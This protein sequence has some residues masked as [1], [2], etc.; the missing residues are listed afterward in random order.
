AL[1]LDAMARQNPAVLAD[2]RLFDPF[3]RSAAGR[4]ALVERLGT[5][6]PW[7]RDYAM[8]VADLPADRLAQRYGVLEALA[9]KGGR[10][11]CTPIGAPVSRLIAA[12]AA[13][14]AARLWRGHCPA[15]ATALL[16][17]GNFAAAS[18]D[19][20]ESEFAWT[21]IGQSDVSVLIEPAATPPAR[22]LV[23]DS[24]APQPRQVLRQLVLLPA[25]AYR[26]SWQ[27]DAQTGTQMLVQFT[28]APDAQA[29]IV[30]QGNPA[31]KRWTATLE[32]DASC[33][34]RWI[35]FVVRPGATNA[36]IADVRL[37]RAG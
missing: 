33:A 34:A 27:G 11:G 15:A 32:M 37:E 30:P 22:G 25:G 3:E 10:V 2:R 5:A 17:D 8:Q 13:P 14:D 1:R 18:L 21:F 24:S 4:A 16:Y 29:A 9:E 28:C 6:P 31:S 23:I 12:G 26:L 35:G 36:Q 19:Q 7:L 20:S